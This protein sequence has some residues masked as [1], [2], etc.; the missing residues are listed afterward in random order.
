M[1]GALSL[2]DG[3]AAK[4]VLVGPRSE[5]KG[6]MLVIPAPDGQSVATVSVGE[7][8]ERLSREQLIDVLCA[9]ERSF[10]AN[11]LPPL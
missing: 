6:A 4:I 8:H 2:T 10:G 5:P 9:Q 1:V 7:A 11:A 3:Q